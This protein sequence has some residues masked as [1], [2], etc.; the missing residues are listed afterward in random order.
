MRADAKYKRERKWPQ[1]RFQLQLVAKSCRR[2]EWVSHNIICCTVC[3]WRMIITDN[4]C[5][6]LFSGVHKLTALYSILHKM[7]PR[8]KCWLI[9]TFTNGKFTY[10]FRFP[11]LQRF[12]LHLMHMFTGLCSLTIILP[13]LCLIFG[14]ASSVDLFTFELNSLWCTPY[15]HNHLAVLKLQYTHCQDCHNQIKNFYATHVHAVVPTPC[16]SDFVVLLST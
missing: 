3:L 6:A 15:I 14:S 13:K 9:Q 5:I 10:C 1:P 4:C 11:V 12:P 8:T 7:I 16:L 2:W